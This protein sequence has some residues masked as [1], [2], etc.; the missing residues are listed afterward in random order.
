MMDYSTFYGNEAFQSA[1]PP[2][3]SIDDVGILNTIQQFME[4]GKTRCTGKPTAF[5]KTM[6]QAST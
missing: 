3:K 4:T 1:H 2:S 5:E 6:A